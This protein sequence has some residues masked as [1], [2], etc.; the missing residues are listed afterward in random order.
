[1]HNVE[2]CLW[3]QNKNVI[4]FS[5]PMSRGMKIIQLD[6]GAFDGPPEGRSLNSLMGG[7][8]GSFAIC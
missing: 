6:F 5:A 2:I 3:P 7:S 8:G 1:M 4:L